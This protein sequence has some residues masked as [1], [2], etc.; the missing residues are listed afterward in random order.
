MLAGCCCAKDPLRPV[1]IKTAAKWTILLHD[2]G[3]HCWHLVL[4]LMPS[5]ACLRVTTQW[6]FVSSTSLVSEGPACAGR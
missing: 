3:E 1:D 5:T 6:N 4:P 2:L